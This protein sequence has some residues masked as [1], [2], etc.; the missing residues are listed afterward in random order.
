MAGANTLL[1]A[2]LPAAD[3]VYNR[4]WGYGTV[5]SLTKD[6]LAGEERLK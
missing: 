6:D 1:C 4:E 3:S 2:L 5:E